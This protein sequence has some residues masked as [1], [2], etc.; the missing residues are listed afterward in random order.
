VGAGEQTSVDSMQIEP[1]SQ[2]PDPE[3][4]TS[5]QSGRLAFRM[6]PL[7]DVLQ[8]INRYSRKPIVIADPAIADI[9]VTGTVV[10][11]NV[12]GWVASLRSALGLAAVD[13]PDR[14][15]LQRAR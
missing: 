6:Q 8:Q 13:E 4:A 9:K 15:V 7:E 3:D 2:I 14:I 11:G 12:S 1:P 10:G 5:W